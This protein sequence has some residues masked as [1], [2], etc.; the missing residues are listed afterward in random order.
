MFKKTALFSGDGFPYQPRY[1]Y[2]ADS[3]T[4]GAGEG[5]WVKTDI[6][7]GAL[8]ISITIQRTQTFF[9]LG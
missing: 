7:V 6:R 1:V 5:L 3:Q 4:E 9:A 2:V 8:F